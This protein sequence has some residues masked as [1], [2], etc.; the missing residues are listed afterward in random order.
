MTKLP[1]GFYIHDVY[2]YR[3]AT[4]DRW[5]FYYIP[6]APKPEINAFGKPTISLWASARGA[7]LQLQ[8]RWDVETNLLTEIKQEL[9][10]LYPELDADL[11]SLELAPVISQGVTLLIGDGNNQF[12]DLVTVNSSGASPYATIFNLRL[13]ATD[14][15]KVLSTFNGHQNYLILKYQFSLEVASGRV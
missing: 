5:S 2:C 9:S 10:K 11:I 15:A 14:K 7:I 13:T 1:D 6:G 8:T 4:L 12:Q 3:D